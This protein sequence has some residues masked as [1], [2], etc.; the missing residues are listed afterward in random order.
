MDS[1]NALLRLFMRQAQ[2]ER[3]MKRPGNAHLIEEPELNSVKEPL[4]GMPDTIERLAKQQEH[5]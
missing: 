3:A 4:A 1:L 5:D 2:L